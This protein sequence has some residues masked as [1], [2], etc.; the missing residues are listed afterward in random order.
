MRKNTARAL[1]NFLKGK[2]DIPSLHGSSIWSDGQTLWSYHTALCTWFVSGA[3]PT[4]RIPRSDDRRALALNMTK[5][6]VTT[7]QHQYAIR[8]DLT[9]RGCLKAYDPDHRRWCLTN[10]A[11][12][13]QEVC[14][15][16]QGIGRETLAEY[17]SHLLSACYAADNA[18]AA[19]GLR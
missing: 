10:S 11:P 6:S 1:T 2:A 13:V 16:D 17:A 19:A 9:L 15:A 14:D 3:E 8:Y 4:S 18:L 12:L 5:Y 7:T